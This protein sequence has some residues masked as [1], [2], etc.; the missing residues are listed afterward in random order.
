[1]G[2][3]DLGKASELKD[4]IGDISKVIAFVHEHGDDIV[5][6]VKQTPELLGEAGHGLAAAG[7]AATNAAGFLSGG[8]SP[9]RGLVDVASSALDTCR[10]E[11]VGAVDLIAKLA[12]IVGGVH[13]GAARQLS[14]HGER[15]GGVAAGLATVAEQFRLV[16]ERLNGTG[17]DLS[18]VGDHLQS[19]GNRLASIGPS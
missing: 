11:L 2:L 12:E 10:D 5:R 3:F 7:T 14:S 17:D 6:W 4:M 13:D 8:D 1:M 9:L 16:G 18:R 19:T 15:L